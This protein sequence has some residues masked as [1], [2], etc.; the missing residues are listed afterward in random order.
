MKRSLDTFS[1][2]HLEISMA[3]FFYCGRV[4]SAQLDCWQAMLQRP[5]IDQRLVEQTAYRREI[6][7][8]GYKSVFTNFWLLCQRNRSWIKGWGKNQHKEWT[9]S[10]FA[11]PFVRD[12]PTVTTWTPRNYC[13]PTSRPQQ[14]QATRGVLTS[15]P[16]THTEI[17]MGV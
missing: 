11:V 4:P 9:R 13:V 1:H 2:W 12:H 10:L 16:A 8:S 5:I 7:G 17:G 6:K 3:S 14:W 15:L